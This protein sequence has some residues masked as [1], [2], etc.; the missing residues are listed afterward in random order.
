MYGHTKRENTLWKGWWRV[1]LT[2][3]SQFLWSCLWS[4]FWVF[5]T[6]SVLWFIVPVS[7]NCK[8]KRKP[9]LMRTSKIRH[10]NFCYL[11]CLILKLFETYL[12]LFSPISSFDAELVWGS[13]NMLFV[14]LWLAECVWT[15]RMFKCRPAECIST[16]KVFKWLLEVCTDQCSLLSLWSWCLINDV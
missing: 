5:Q 12:I 4:V 16:A 6:S 15:A 1:Y 13:S 3:N 9:C 2:K 14:M 8:K 7:Y 11:E 10:M